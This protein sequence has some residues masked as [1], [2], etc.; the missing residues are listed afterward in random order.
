M[1]KGKDSFP[2]KNKMVFIFHIKKLSHFQSQEQNYIEYYYLGYSHSLKKLNMI[3]FLTL[4][5]RLSTLV[6]C[7]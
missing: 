2:E 1:A 4:F 5:H 7:N 6:H 3:F